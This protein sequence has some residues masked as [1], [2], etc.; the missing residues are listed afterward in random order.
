MIPIAC[1]SRRSIDLA[2]DIAYPIRVRMHEPLSAGSARILMQLRLK[3]N[4]APASIPNH[5]STPANRADIVRRS[6]GKRR[7]RTDQKNRQKQSCQHSLVILH[8]CPLPFVCCRHNVA[9]WFIHMIVLPERFVDFS[10]RFLYPSVKLYRMPIRLSRQTHRHA[11]K[12][13]LRI[14]GAA[15]PAPFSSSGRS[16]TI[17]PP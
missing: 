16:R 8:D 14:Y 1:V 2:A 5:T 11:I 6:I 12:N 15:S 3:T 13:L 7:R 10:P 9:L 4:G 17:L